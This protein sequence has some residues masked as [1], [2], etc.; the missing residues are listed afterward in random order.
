MSEYK[1]D[2]MVKENDKWFAEIRDEDNNK[3][4]TGNIYG[5]EGMSY[6]SLKCIL[7]EYYNIDI[8]KIKDLKILKKTS[9][10][11]VYVLNI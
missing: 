3:E 9:N 11:T 7:S 5:R 10:R 6:S 1:L 8:P 2:H 4:H